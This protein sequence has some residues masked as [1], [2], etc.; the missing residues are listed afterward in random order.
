MEINKKAIIAGCARNCGLYL[1]K[2]INNIIKISSKYERTSFFICE[3]DSKDN[4]KKVLK[5]WV[6]KTENATLTPIFAVAN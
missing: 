6:E 4:T 5:N 2:V 1:P 3:N